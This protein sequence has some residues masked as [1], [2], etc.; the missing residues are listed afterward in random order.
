MPP[1]CRV[2]DTARK[3]IYFV[4]L[5]HPVGTLRTLSSKRLASRARHRRNETGGCRRREPPGVWVVAKH[6]LRWM[7]IL[8]CGR[9]VDC[10]G[11]GPGGRATTRPI[12]AP[13]LCS[14]IQQ[15]C[16][17]IIHS[18]VLIAKIVWLARMSRC[19]R[20]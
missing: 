1:T 9:G 14:G 18:I 6:D 15:G 19:I 3:G 8:I 2:S 10:V 17:S 5:S 13:L 12:T 20:R 4:Q 7:A 16:D 11:P